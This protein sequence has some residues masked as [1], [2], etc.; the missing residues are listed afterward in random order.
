MNTKKRRYQVI[1][2]YRGS[3]KEAESPLLSEEPKKFDP[4]ATTEDLIADL[5]RVQEANPGSFITRKAY[6]RLG[7]YSDSTWDSRFGTFAEF[8]KQARLELSRGQQALE[9]QIAKHA[10]LDT[11][12]GFME[13]EVLPWNG[14]YERDHSGRWQTMVVASDFHDRETDP[15]VLEVFLDTVRRVTP[16]KVVLGGDVFDSYEFSRFDKDPRQ[17]DAAGRLAWVRDNLFHPLRE[18]CPDAQIDLIAGNH[19]HHMLRHMS[20]RTPEMRA[21]LADFMGLTLSDLLGLKAFEINLSCQ[22]D[23]SAFNPADVRREIRKNRKT[24]WKTV[25]VDHYSDPQFSLGTNWVS[26]H[27]HKPGLYTHCNEILGS[28]WGW[29]NGCAARIDNSYTDRNRNQHSLAIVHADTHKDTATLEP[30]L[31][32]DFAAVI[33]GQRYTR[34]DGGAA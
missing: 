23:L 18:A 27:T 16:D 2:E 22:H 4:T 7:S 29:Q 24:Y 10:S 3:H 8:R 17:W 19:E 33:G 5:R 13:V 28:I 34:I 32:S 15:F 20:E 12:R 31:F 6:R 14:R 11:R 9:R 1:Q 30:V 21:I 26:G 25:T